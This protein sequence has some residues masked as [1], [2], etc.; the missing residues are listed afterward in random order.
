MK[1]EDLMT[2]NPITVSPETSAMDI[3]Q[4][5]EDKHLIRMPVVNEEGHLMGIV[6]RRDILLGYLN[7]T[8]ITK[9]F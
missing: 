8:R 2:P 9:V 7:A 6:S 3:M 5:L 1:A 4:K